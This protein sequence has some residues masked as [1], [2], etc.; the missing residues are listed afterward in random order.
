[1][2]AVEAI[3]RKVG[4]DMR[5]MGLLPAGGIHTLYI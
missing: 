1:M 5:E 2:I 4:V 3:V